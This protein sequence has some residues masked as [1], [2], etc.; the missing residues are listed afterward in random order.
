MSATTIEVATPTETADPP[1]ERRLSQAAGSASDAT[2]PSKTL[3]V[4]PT[5]IASCNLRLLS[6]SDVNH[7]HDFDD[8]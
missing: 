7:E 5:L 8:I 3:G 4:T 1:R 6:S 2:M